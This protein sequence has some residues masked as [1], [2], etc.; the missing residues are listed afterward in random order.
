MNTITFRA[1]SAEDIPLICR[2]RKTQLLGNGAPAADVES[3]DPY[4]TSFFEENFRRGT[5]H[6][7]FAMDGDR[8]VGT[9]GVLFFAYPPSHVNKSGQIAYITNMF[10][11]PDY[12]RQGIAGTILG[13]LEEEARSRGV[14]Q[15]KLGATRWG[16]SLYEKAGYTEDDLS[17]LVKKL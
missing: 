3:L 14:T 11:D 1:A 10:T 4:L 13:M 7:I 17:D 15:A 6:Q 8:A 9:G 5:I 12:R 2:F 16:K